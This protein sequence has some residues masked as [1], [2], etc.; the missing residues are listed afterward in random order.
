MIS[1]LKTVTISDQKFQFTFSFSFRFFFYAFN[2][3]QTAFHHSLSFI[4]KVRQRCILFYTQKLPE[5]IHCLNTGYADLKHNVWSLFNKYSSGN[6]FECKEIVQKEMLLESQ[7][8]FCGRMEKYIAQHRRQ[9]VQW[10]IIHTFVRKLIS[11]YVKELREYSKT[12]LSQHV[13]DNAH[14]TNLE[15]TSLQVIYIPTNSVVCSRERN[16]LM[17]RK[18]LHVNV[19]LRRLE[20]MLDQTSTQDETNHQV[21]DVE[22]LSPEKKLSNLFKRCVLRS[23][24]PVGVDVYTFGKVNNNKL[25]LVITVLK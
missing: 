11:F 21:A 4:S 14:V 8:K 6:P 2:C 10:L 17:P 15:R 9:L 25:K 3:I 23:S 1:P 5:L 20:N 7:A 16:E 19:L 12:N 24:A 22:D 18:Q 13:E